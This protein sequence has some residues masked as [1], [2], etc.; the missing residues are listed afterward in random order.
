MT[1]IRNTHTPKVEA[2]FQRVKGV[3]KVVSGYMGGSV[4]NP[5]YEQVC[6]GKTGHAEVVQI[7]YKSSEVSFK[8]ILDV[9]WGCHDPTT[10]NRQGTVY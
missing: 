2:I 3:E 4:V 10:L 8:E 1:V 5:T 7:T 6:T 9:F